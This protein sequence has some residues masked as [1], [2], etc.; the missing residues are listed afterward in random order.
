MKKTIVAISVIAIILVALSACQKGP[1]EKAGQALDNTG[2]AVVDTVNP[3]GPA[4]KAGKKIDQAT[5]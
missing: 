3:S 4:Q 2:K 5:Q 1:A